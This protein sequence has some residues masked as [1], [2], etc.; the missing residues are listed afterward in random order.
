MAMLLGSF[1]LPRRWTVTGSFD[2][3]KSPF[4]T[5]RNALAGQPVQS[6]DEL[7]LMFGA[8]AVR[9]QSH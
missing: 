4:L 6:L 7:I 1:D 2:R 8:D 5:T 9:A 3:R